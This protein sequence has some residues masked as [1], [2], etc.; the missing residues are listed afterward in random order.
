MT[1]PFDALR[2]QPELLT[3][4]MNDAKILLPR[5]RQT[6]IGTENLNGCTAIAILGHAIILAHISPYPP[7]GSSPTQQH[8]DKT[9]GEQHLDK[10]LARV[11]GIFKAYPL[12]F[13][14]ETTT[15]GFFGVLPGQGPM[16]HIVQATEQHIRQLGLKLKPHYYQVTDSTTKKASSSQV[17][18]VVRADG[19]HLYCQD[20]KLEH[21]PVPKTSS[22]KAVAS[23][24]KGSQVVAGGTGIPSSSS[25]SLPQ[26]QMTADFAKAAASRQAKEAFARLKAMGSSDAEAIARLTE[27]LQKQNPQMSKQQATQSVYARLQYNG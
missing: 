16:V 23:S 8:P 20:I 13:P 6:A 7:P 14:P 17:V 25:I 18:A 26:P 27:A 1:T 9:P 12:M 15:W 21:K 22:G 5:S 19:T 3:V 2:D 10:W 11:E 4:D 24:S